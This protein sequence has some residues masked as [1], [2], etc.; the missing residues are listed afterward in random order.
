MISAILICI[1]YADYFSFSAKTLGRTFERVVVI[2]EPG[3]DSVLDICSKFNFEYVLSKKKNYRDL[4]FNLPA[5]LNDGINQKGLEGWICKM[6]SD[7]YIPDGMRAILRSEVTDVNKIYC[8][9]RYFCETPNILKSY[10]E[11]KDLSV[12]E[13]PFED[14]SEPLGF[15]QLF[16][17]SSKYL[18]NYQLPYEQEFYAPPSLTNDRLFARQWPESERQLLSK[19]VIHLGLDAIGTNWFGRKSEKFI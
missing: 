15:M 10:E 7:I 16:N 1:D 11:R 12:L 6:D 9:N 2:T 8:A 19:S 4:K 5:L 3:Q 17:R 14:M 18:K 13:P